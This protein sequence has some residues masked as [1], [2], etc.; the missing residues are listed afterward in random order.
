MDFPRDLI[1]QLQR[2]QLHDA[3]QAGDLARVKALLARKYPVNR[4]DKLGKTPL[5]HAVSKGH[6]SV[7]QE[8]IRAGANVNAHDERVIGN[9]PLSDSVREC[10]LEMVKCLI[11]AGADPTIRGWMQLNAIDR[12][13]ERHDAHATRILRL[14][15]NVAQ[16]KAKRPG[17]DQCS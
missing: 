3:A 13:K 17:S 8:L 6:L 14:L 9:T 15:E 5:H 1:A 4:F 7:V 12:A 10:S 2:E 11:D 16:G